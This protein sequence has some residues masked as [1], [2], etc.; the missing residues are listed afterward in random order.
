MTLTEINQATLNPAFHRHSD[1]SCL[2][3]EEDRADLGWLEDSFRLD[4]HTVFKDGQDLHKVA[5][6]ELSSVSP[7]SSISNFVQSPISSTIHTVHGELNDTAALGFANE[8]F[9]DNDL[10]LELLE[11]TE[12]L[13]EMGMTSPLTK[14]VTPG[15]RKHQSAAITIERVESTPESPNLPT[16]IPWMISFDVEGNPIP[17]IRPS[18]PTVI[19]DRSPIL[20][21]TSRM[22][23]RTC[24]RIGEAL[25][26]ASAASRSKAD[27]VI[28]LYA[29]VETS[30]RELGSFKQKFHFS[31]LF[32]PE[33]PPFLAGTYGLWRGSQL[34]DLDSMGF[35]GEKGRGKLARAVGRIRREE[36]S[37]KW[38]M[39]ILSVWL[40]DW[41]DVGMAK[42]IVLS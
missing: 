35:I 3:D 22:V 9:D 33:K 18:F 15:D 24:F 30:E 4:K 10:D 6:N 25:N 13:C 41:D 39:T 5:P 31:D 36:Q 8:C 16:E 37:Q 7:S 26:A 34:W 2:G 29:R 27:A 23:L 12:P 32:T 20:G 1:C 11:M 14:V 38:E 40:V 21:L 28:E 17:F 42:G 19:R